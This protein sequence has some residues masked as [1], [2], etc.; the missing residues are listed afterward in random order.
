MY[1]FILVY[2]LNFPRIHG[3]RKTG[4]L[5]FSQTLH[6]FYITAWHT[7]HTQQNPCWVKKY[8]DY[9]YTNYTVFCLKSRKTKNHHQLLF[10]SQMYLYCTWHKIMSQI[11][12][13]GTTKPIK[14]ECEVIQSICTEFLK[15]TKNKLN[16]K[17]TNK[18]IMQVL[19]MT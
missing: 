10:T 12:I 16:G 2:L 11:Q 7:I 8:T 3:L 13:L 15:C 6:S 17:A 4:S 9:V 19:T 14:Y 18:C 1:L 5:S